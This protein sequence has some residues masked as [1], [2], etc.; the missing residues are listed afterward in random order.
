MHLYAKMYTIVFK[1]YF[2]VKTCLLYFE[3]MEILLFFRPKKCFLSAG[4]VV[5]L[6]SLM[7][8]VVCFYHT[9]W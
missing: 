9:I 7:V 1:S 2:E 4:Q 6:E 8:Y 5:I 3:G